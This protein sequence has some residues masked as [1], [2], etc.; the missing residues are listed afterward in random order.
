MPKLSCAQLTFAVPG[1]SVPA[2]SVPSALLNLKSV[3]MDEE[4]TSGEGGL[5]ERVGRTARDGGVV[6]VQLLRKCG[7]THIQ[8]V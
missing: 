6:A 7:L 5:A 1:V 4:R 3:S 8:Q 2:V